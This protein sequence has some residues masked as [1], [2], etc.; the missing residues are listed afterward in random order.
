MFTKPLIAVS[1]VLALSACSGLDDHAIEKSTMTESI[2]NVD[3]AEVAALPEAN[4][5]KHP[6][7][8]PYQ[9]PPFDK[10]N[11]ADVEAAIM[12][13]MVEMLA[14][15]N[16]I[17]NNPAPATFDNTLVPLEQSGALYQRGL[18]ILFNLGSSNGTPERLALMAKISPL[19]SQQQDNIYLNAKLYQRFTEVKASRDSAN[20]NPEQ[21]R[22]IDVYQQ[23]F[24][25]AG[26]S[27]TQAQQTEVRKLNTRLS[28]L[29]TEFGQNVLQ[30][31]QADAVLVEDAAELSGLSE[32]EI[33]SAKMA[34]EKAG[35]SDGYLLTLVNTT[36][37]SYLTN[38]H[39]REL[40]QQVWQA[41]ANRANH[42]KFDNT[43]VALEIAKLRAQKAALFGYA[44][45]ADY[46]LKTQMAQSSDTVFDLL[47]SMVPKVVINADTEAKQ[48]KA[49]MAQQGIKH[50][51]QP[52]DWFYYGEQVR[53]QKYQLDPA[54]VAQYLPFDRVLH[55]G[56]F[57]AM[58]RQFGITFKARPD[59]PTYHEDVDAYE[60]FDADGSSMGLF[61]A[62]YFAREGKRG[63]AWMNAFVTQSHLLGT[64]PV[65]FNVMNIPKAAEGQPQLVSF[66]E[67][68]TMFHEFGHGVHGLFSD[69]TYPSLA[70]TSVSRDF[71][72]FP[73]T[74]Q[75]DW[76]SHPDVISN[77]AKH[78]QT[79]E[80]IP[81]DLLQKVL[82]AGKFNQGFDTLEYLSSA[83]L[84]MEW[85]SVSGDVAISD[86]EAFEKE[87][88]AKHGINVA[89]IPPR[90]KSSY[91]SHIFAGGY[92]AGYYAYMWSEILAADAFAYIR[93]H[94]GLSREQGEKFRK[95][96][97]S[98]GNSQDLME[99]Y[100]GFRGSEPTTEALLIR[101]GIN[102]SK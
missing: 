63:G 3:V 22:L 21:K 34:A 48:I 82:A 32:V 75:E 57:Y 86:I 5:L 12:A 16:A 78:Y 55:D 4:A 8:L 11:D 68:T 17:A 72:E 73:S 41:S 23:Q 101:R 81:A 60:I 87:A 20:L 10:I 52:W 66:D 90:Y 18:S 89:A 56:V 76:A 37:Q 58:E 92:S 1:V 84:D 14:Q 2:I 93:E 49:L 33:G 79:G 29:T 65:I 28:E 85:H 64:K 15:V 69:V 39:S 6:S 71:V 45:W 95:E 77:Y 97:L 40:R 19:V 54:E 102:L 96:I 94:G 91:F 7:V 47:G 27:L 46:Q 9:L 74:F 50:E 13:G 30:A 53:Q 36:R 61:L 35:Y 26:A 99:T 98:M 88:L 38:L 31:S 24:D 51:L 83:L 25:Q 80:P 100:K 62:D 67:A 59:L 70:G 43:P 44:T 42:G